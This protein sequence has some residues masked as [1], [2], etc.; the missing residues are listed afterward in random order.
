LDG[1]FLIRTWPTI[2]ERQV[3]A[4]LLGLLVDVALGVFLAMP[5]YDEIQQGSLEKRLLLMSFGGLQYKCRRK[6]ASWMR[7][8]ASSRL[9]P[10]RRRNF[11]RL[12]MRCFTGSMAGR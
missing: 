1:E 5:V 8:S 9:S 2:D 4:K 6:N 10:R 7:S 3:S 11:F 12:R